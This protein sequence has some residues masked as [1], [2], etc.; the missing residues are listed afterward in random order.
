MPSARPR[1]VSAFLILYRNYYFNTVLYNSNG[2]I[3]L[4]LIHSFVY[5]Y[6]NVEDI[7]LL[8]CAFSVVNNNEAKIPRADL[9]LLISLKHLLP[10]HKPRP[11]LYFNISA[12]KI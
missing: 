5:N 2:R 11:I 9:K 12:N 8:Y 4:Y 6:F 3:F 7:S 1:I 10:N